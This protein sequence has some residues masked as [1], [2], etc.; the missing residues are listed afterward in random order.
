MIVLGVIAGAAGCSAPSTSP[1]SSS[2]VQTVPSASLTPASGIPS[3]SLAL[4][5]DSLNPGALLPNINSCTGSSESP[6]VSWDRIPDGTKSLVLILD[7]PDA[8]SGTFTH[9]LVYNIPPVTVRFSRAQPDQKV[10]A[11]GAQQ[12]DNSA[13][14]RGYYPPCPPIGTTH[15]YIFRLYAVDMVIT[16]PTANR[17]SIDAALVG[18]TLGK[19]EFVTSFTR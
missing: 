4:H 17:E 18:H 5:V 16:Q 10:L 13:G 1:V 7:D 2:A 6:E 3:E 11:N 9:W 12:G 19:A 15:R 14:S 8:P